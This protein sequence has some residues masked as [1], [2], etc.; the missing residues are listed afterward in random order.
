MNNF[1]ESHS[2]CPISGSGKLVRLDGYEKHYLVK[3][4]PVNFVFCSRIPT[5]E[6]L[7]KHY[8]NYPTDSYYSPLTRKS[9]GVLLDGFEKYRK[10][11][12][13]LDVGCGTGLFLE[14]AAKRGWKVYGTEFSAKN[15]SICRS[16]NINMQE[17]KFDPQWYEKDMFDVVTSFEV[18]EHIN[19]PVEEITNIHATLRKG[20][21]LYITT[22]NFNAIERFILKAEYNV[23]EYPEHLSYYTPKTLDFLLRKS[24][25]AK[26]RLTTTGISLTRLKASL[27]G[28]DK[29]GAYQEDKGDAVTQKTGS[30]YSADELIRQKAA[31]N[32]VFG[33]AKS[34]TNR[35]LTLAGVGNAIK[36]WYEK[37]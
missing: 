4:L 7:T 31:E 34:L 21:L 37:A 35:I 33:M 1:F 8:E 5:L 26:R 14:E 10:T 17:G 24:G 16:R 2:K 12:N 11:G 36:G 28:N 25:F 22:P 23:I 18:I 19:N 6:E 3:S 9:Y 29:A 20:G 30:T 13:I 15:V 27:H 32:P